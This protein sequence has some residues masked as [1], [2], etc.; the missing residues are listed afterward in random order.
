VKKI[1]WTINNGNDVSATAIINGLDPLQWSAKSLPL[2]PGFNLITVKATDAA[3]NEGQDT[4]EV[5]YLPPPEIVT[6]LERELLNVKTKFTFYFGDPTYL[7]VDRFSVVANLKNN[8][9][10]TFILPHHE[11]VNILVTMQDPNNASN[12]L[13][14]FKTTIPADSKFVSG[15][16]KYLYRNTG[17][18]IQ[19]LQIYRQTATISYL[20]I[21]VDKIEM[22]RELKSA[23]APAA[24]QAFVKSIKSYTMT[25]QF[26]EFSYTGTASLSPGTAGTYKQELVFNR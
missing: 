21:F 5:N 11:D 8:V 3:G 4:L 14:V 7:N 1:V 2:S 15:T 19:E 25:V 16:T 6:T 10:D 24:F 20:Y 26:G 12:H 18:G 23:M 9:G 17:S 13:E 22:M